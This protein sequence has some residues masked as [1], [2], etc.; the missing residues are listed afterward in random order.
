M[1]NAKVSDKQIQQKLKKTATKGLDMD[2]K[3]ILKILFTE[4]KKINIQVRSVLKAE[5]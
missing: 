1:T 2:W 4:Q 3:H 5:T